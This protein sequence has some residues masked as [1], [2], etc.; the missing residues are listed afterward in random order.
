M[1]CALQIVANSDLP[2]P[3]HRATD[4][5][6]NHAND[7]A[8]M[9]KNERVVAGFGVVGLVLDVRFRFA[10]ILEQHLAANTMKC[11]PLFGALRCS[12]F[13]LKPSHA[14][15]VYSTPQAESSELQ[16]NE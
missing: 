13:V 16:N 6:A 15:N 10:A 2:K 7:D 9:K 5:Y 8:A 1:A 4:L 11:T 14:Y 12:Q 3:R